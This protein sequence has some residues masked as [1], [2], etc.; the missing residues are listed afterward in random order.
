MFWTD[1][2]AV[3]RIL[4]GR[5][6]LVFR[7]I[8]LGECHLGTDVQQLADF[9]TD[10]FVIVYQVLPS[11][12][13]ERTDIVLVILKEGRLAIGCCQGVPVQM[14]PV[15]VVTDADILNQVRSPVRWGR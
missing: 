5:R 3:V 4:M 11:L 10:R 8:L 1:A 13:E 7:Q 14:S 15:A 9:L 2:L 6:N 12:F